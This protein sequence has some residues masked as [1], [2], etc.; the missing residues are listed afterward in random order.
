MFS[1]S[2]MITIRRV[3]ARH[4]LH[5]LYTRSVVTERTSIVR[6]NVFA[7]CVSLACL[8]SSA[9]DHSASRGSFT[10]TQ[11]L[12]EWCKEVTRGY[13]GVKVT[14]MTTSWRNGLAFCAVIHHF[15][16]DLMYEFT[17]SC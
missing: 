2:V 16:P 17:F 4:Y 11:D 10:P 6:V 15:H 12:L 14:N 3:T 8:Q 13:K 1:F 7:V 5:C 9:T